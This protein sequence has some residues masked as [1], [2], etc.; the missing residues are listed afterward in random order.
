MVSTSVDQYLVGMVV[1][2]S[3]SVLTWVS[4]FVGT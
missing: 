2:L 4:T 3:E 1:L